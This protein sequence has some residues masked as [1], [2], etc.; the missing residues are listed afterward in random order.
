MHDPIREIGMVAY[1][2]VKSLIGGEN[3]MLL[4]QGEREAEAI[5]GRMIEIEG[6]TRRG[7]SELPEPRPAPPSARPRPPQNPPW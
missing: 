5:I 2:L 3:G 6:R 4:L 1:D 7:R